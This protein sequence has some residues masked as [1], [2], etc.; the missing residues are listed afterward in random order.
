M[1][2][3][4]YKQVKTDSAADLGQYMDM[5]FSVQRV[6][7]ISAVAPAKDAPAK[8]IR[9]RRRRRR[10]YLKITPELVK[11]MT[12]LRKKGMVYRIIGRRFG[13]TGARAWQ[14]VRQGG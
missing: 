8:G 12:S 14:I 5:G 3:L 10:A 11:Q 9:R 7:P 4:V 1:E 2:F 6:R 13:V